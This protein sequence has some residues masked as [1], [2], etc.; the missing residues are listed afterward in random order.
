[1][2]IIRSTLA[3]AAAT[4]IAGTAIAAEFTLPGQIAW[5]AYGTGS[6]G[7]NQ[8]V[9][10]G[11][12]LQ[13]AAGV[14][15]RVLPGK[16]DV[17]RTEPLRQGKVEFSATGVGGSFMA[18][19]G[20][21]AF[22]TAGWGPQEV[23]VLIANNGGKV[24]L[25]MAV[26]AEAC[27][28]AGKPGCE[29]FEYSDLKGLRV[30]WVKGAPALNVNNLAYLSYGGLSWDDVEKVEFGGFSDSWKGMVNGQVDAAFASTNS[31]KAYEAAAGPRGVFWP[32]VDPAN[33]DGLA[34]MNAIAPFFAPMTAVVGANIDGG[35]GV[36]TAGYAYP[37]LVAMVG[38]DAGLVYN[39]TK[40]MV[41][42]FPAY[43][44]NAPGI[45]GWAL[46]KQ[47]F[48]WVAPYH[49]GAIR[50][51]NEIG[52]WNDAAQAHNDMLVARQA[53]LKAAWEELK[54]AAPA[55]WEAAWDAKRRE[56]LAAGG[57]EI[58]F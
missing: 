54:A 48:Q 22:G 19:E 46:E 11:A 35:P 45:G 5:T 52:A 9:A 39:M 12:A 7:Y 34:R 27:E 28:K 44:G 31:G 15:L 6:A 24:G 33:T 57:F 55:D 32:P 25:A 42:L 29:G 14:N 53:A 49:D 30:A 56:A 17:A 13:D 36:A 37:V 58:V 20:V 38:Q 21:F 10:I 47:D 50:Y 51:Y 8:S 1:M 26:A 16:N 40:A 2:L 43:D 23:R 18:Q 41:D 4:L 3:A